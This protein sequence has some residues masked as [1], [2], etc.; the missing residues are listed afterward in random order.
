[1]ANGPLQRQPIGRQPG[2][3]SCMPDG[4]QYTRITATSA[5]DVLKDASNVLNANARAWRRTFQEASNLMSR[6]ATE[7]GSPG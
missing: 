4:R 1:M 6:Y 7:H 2:A 3:G 5:E